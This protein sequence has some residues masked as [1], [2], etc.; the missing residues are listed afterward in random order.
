M[1]IVVLVVFVCLVATLGLIASSGFFL[2][3]SLLNHPCLCERV[4]VHVFCVHDLMFVVIARMRMRRFTSIRG[5]V[6]CVYIRVRM[7]VC[8][9]SFCA[10]ACLVLF[11]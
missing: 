2:C 4:S 7:C 1:F 5:S 6:R 3:Q 9:C 8:V 10:N 11:P